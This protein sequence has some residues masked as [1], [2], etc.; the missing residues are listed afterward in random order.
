MRGTKEHGHRKATKEADQLREE[1][2]VRGIV[3]T[4]NVGLNR[5][6]ATLTIAVDGTAIHH[7][8]CHL[9]SANRRVNDRNI[10]GGRREASSKGHGTFSVI[11]SRELYRGSSIEKKHCASPEDTKSANGD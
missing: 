3:V 4:S 8:I 2:H 11:I 9:H 5:F 10:A 7:R 1:R 6:V